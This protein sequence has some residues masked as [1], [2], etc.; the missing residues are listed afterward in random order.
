MIVPTRAAVRPRIVSPGSGETILFEDFVETFQAKT[1]RGMIC[2]SGQPGTGKTSAL[3]HL[4]ATLDDS[5]TLVVLDDTPGDIAAEHAKNALV[6]FSCSD[7]LPSGVTIQL[8]KWTNDDAIEYL[9]ARHHDETETIFARLSGAADQYLLCGNAELYSTVVDAMSLDESIVT[10]RD[11][12]FAA[13]QKVLPT[14]VTFKD[15]CAFCSRLLRTNDFNI[16]RAITEFAKEFCDESKIDAALSLE[17]LLRHRSVQTIC[18]AEHVASELA[19]GVETCLLIPINHSSIVEI[20]RRISG[21]DTAVNCL[22][23]LANRLSQSAP[24]AASIMH[25]LEDN[26]LPT[27]ASVSLSNAQLSGAY[28]KG[29][30]FEDSLFSGTDLSESDLASVTIKNSKASYINFENAD[31]ESA[32]LSESDFSGAS[33]RGANLVKIQANRLKL[34][35]ADLRSAR[36]SNAKFTNSSFVQSDLRNACFYAAD[37]SGSVFD[38]SK[39]DGADF[40]NAVFAGAKLNALRLRDSLLDGCDFFQA[41]LQSCDFECVNLRNASFQE[42]NFRNAYLTGS[43]FRNGNLH[44]ANLRMTGLGEIDWEGADLRDADFRGCS[45]HMGSTRSGLV[46]SP[47]PSEG[48]RTG[49][50]TEDYDDQNFK[51]PEEIRKASLK[52][53][54]L[55]GANVDKV[56]FY[57]V[58]LRE[59]IYDARQREQFQRTGAILNDRE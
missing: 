54:D 51:P 21:N 59:A 55:R 56:D 49:F 43:V 35:N 4:A 40:R 57:L 25:F 37:L 22:N 32:T 17:R 20:A 8:A 50:Y 26:W 39:V 12:L 19:S 58:D 33:F 34:A 3:S 6:V 45:F 13:V 18:A 9:L 1:S 29:A 52:G 15:V 24:L 30:Q 47:Y 11:G 44:S 16:K 27:S 10:I 48:T 2:L 36:M 42:A 41:N 31:L 7:R 14:S 46:D 28:W 23:S 5:K 38:S 53:A